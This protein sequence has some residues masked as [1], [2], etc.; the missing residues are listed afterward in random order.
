MPI[1]RTGQFG[2][3]SGG[4][5]P[6]EQVVS[7]NRNGVVNFSEI[8]N[9]AS[10]LEKKYDVKIEIRSEA[11]KEK[12]FSGTFTNETIH[13]ALEALK[14]SY[15]LTYTVNQRLITIKD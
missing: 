9:L 2:P 13:Q 14:L 11:L 10:K 6:A 4:Q 3:K 5:F 15:P 12:R 1:V 7:L 8:S